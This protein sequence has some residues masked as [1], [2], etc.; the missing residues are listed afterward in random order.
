MFHHLFL[1][2]NENKRKKISKV[3]FLYNLACSLF[4]NAFDKSDP[5]FTFKPNFQ[6]RFL[7]IAM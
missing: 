5:C 4:S 1:V 6:Y 3:I 2:P 7:M